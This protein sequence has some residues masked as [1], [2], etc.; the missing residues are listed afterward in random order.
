MDGPIH[1]LNW[2]AGW[3]LI[4]GAFLSGAAMGLSF[5]K[6]EFLG[7]YQSLRRRLVRLGHISLAALGM[8]NLLFASS[9][10]P[11][12]GSALGG[13]ASVCFV[14]G[15]V[16][17]PLVCFLSAW[18]APFRHLFAVPVVALVLAVVFTLAGRLS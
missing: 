15:G 14:T 17:M 8:L 10:W 9:S 1:P 2:Q 5:H 12:P 11:A 18:R 7:G 13:A 3:L 6:E 4:L 16:A